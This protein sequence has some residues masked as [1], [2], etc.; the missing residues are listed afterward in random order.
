VLVFLAY[1]SLSVVRIVPLFV[2]C[3][4][5]L[6]R[7]AFAARWPHVSRGGPPTP[8]EMPVAIGILIASVC[9]A[10][11]LLS[12]SLGCVRVTGDRVADA[13]AV[14]LLM[15]APRGRVV[16]FFDWGQYAIWH[17]SPPLR[18]SMDG[19]RETVYSDS[20]LDE[21]GAILEGTP[22][23]VEALER[24]QAEYV[25]LPATSVTTKAWLLA[26][27]YR[28]EHDT[29]HSFVAV[30]ADLPALDEVGAIDEET[31]ACFPG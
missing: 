1:A 18:V 28:L 24:W 27:G 14:R 16:T 30:R 17:L 2:L 22:A 8:G 10:A 11:W 20:R 3:A 7:P 31:L 15:A 21:H 23:G 25:W 29:T 6:L 9:G 13:R 12:S 26:N 19:R 4:V 5:V